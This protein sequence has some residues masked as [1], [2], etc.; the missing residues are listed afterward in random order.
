M[1]VNNGKTDNTSPDSALLAA[2]L[3]AISE[4]AL[5]PVGR[6]ELLGWLSIQL[7]APSLVL[8]YEWAELLKALVVAMQDKIAAT[9][10]AAEQIFCSLMSR[11]FISRNDVS[12]S[13]RDLPPAT[14]RPLQSAIDRILLV[15]PVAQGGGDMKAPSSPI[16]KEKELE[17]DLSQTT[18]SRPNPKYFPLLLPWLIRS[19]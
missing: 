8:R 16:K 4:A 18:R 6:L 14:L 7:E 13:F 5:N 12:K 1:I 10:T 9:R 17:K 11:G 3:P 2:L 15:T 19:L